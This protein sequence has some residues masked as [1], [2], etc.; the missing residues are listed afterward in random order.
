MRPKIFSRPDIDVPSN[1]R[2]TA[3]AASNRHLL[4]DQAIH[5]NLRLGM[6]DDPVRV[7]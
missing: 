2:H 6:N 4:K 3:S 1:R 7:R 5:A